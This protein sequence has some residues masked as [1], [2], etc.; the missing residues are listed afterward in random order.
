[1]YKTWYHTLFL[2]QW[3]ILNR[4]Q[5]KAN[6]TTDNHKALTILYLTDSPLTK[7]TEESFET[8]LRGVSNGTNA[9][10]D[11]K[12]ESVLLP[13]NSASLLPTLQVLN[14]SLSGEDARVIILDVDEDK[15]K[16]VSLLSWFGLMFDIRTR[17]VGKDGKVSL[18]LIIRHVDSSHAT[19]TRAG[20]ES[21]FL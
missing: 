12:L 15:V 2:I 7:I 5:P 8:F 18:L 21:L 6:G 3:V 17:P 9:K 4:V 11:V 20:L 14:S 1:M 16:A 10:S 13:N 19:W